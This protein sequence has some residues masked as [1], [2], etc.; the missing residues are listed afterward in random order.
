MAVLDGVEAYLIVNRQPM[1][2]LIDQEYATDAPDEIIRYVEAVSGES[3]QIYLRAPLYADVRDKLFQVRVYV[4]GN[5]VASSRH[6]PEVQQGKEF[7]VI[8]DSA[9]QNIMGRE[10]AHDLYF[11][12]VIIGE[13]DISRTHPTTCLHYD[14]HRGQRLLRHA[15]GP[16][17][18]SW[19]DPCRT[20]ATHEFEESVYSWTSGSYDCLQ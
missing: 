3:F 17:Q 20:L 8:V 18:E 2:E 12:D 5:K 16:C 11:K 6:V 1:F 9:N 15:H 13:S 19:R 7:E 4:D 14:L 10:T